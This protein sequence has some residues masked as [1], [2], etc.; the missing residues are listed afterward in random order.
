MLNPL[1]H[2]RVIHPTRKHPEEHWVS[3]WYE[4]DR[5]HT[6][7]YSHMEHTRREIDKQFMRMEKAMSSA[8]KEI[9]FPR[10]HSILDEIENE[11]PEI[12]EE[13]DH[14]KYRLNLHVGEDFEPEDIKVKLKHHQ[15]TV[16]AKSEHKSPDGHSRVYHEVEKKFT[17]P[18]DV[19]VRDVRSTLEPD[20]CLTIEAPLPH[21]AIEEKKRIKEPKDI[22]VQVD[23]L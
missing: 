16:E 8:F 2:S 10:W 15:M 21:L 13:G 6:S 19:D 5:H 9:G 14:K 7:H 23:S 20:G 22:P 11:T 12:V 4:H 3:P 18:D 1:H 17:L